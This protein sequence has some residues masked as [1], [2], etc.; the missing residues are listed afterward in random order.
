[1]KRSPLIILFITIFVDLLGFGLVIPLIPIYIQHYGG[2]PWIGGVLL[3]CYS[4]MQFIFSPI[5]GRASDRIGR[6]PL[7]L[8]SLFGS[9]ISFVA[10]GAAGTLAVLFIARVSAGILSAASL[11]AAYAYIADVT[12]PEKR[13]SGMA[14]I[15]AAFGLGFALGPAISGPLS[16]HPVFGIPPLAMPAYFAA[17]LCT[18]NFIWAFFNLPETHT[19]RSAHSE[20]KGVM[21]ILNGIGRALKDPSVKYQLTVFAFATFAFTAVESTFSWLTILRFKDEIDKGALAAWH[22]YSHLSFAAVPLEVRRLIPKGVP[23]PSYADR[24]LSSIDPPIARLLMEKAAASITTKIFMIVGITILF[25]QV[26]VMRG[27]AAKFGEKRLIIT[28]ALILTVTLFGIAMAQS[29]LWIEI[30]SAFIAVGNGI[31]NPCLSSLISQAA[32]KLNRGTVLGAQQ[33]IG[34]LARIIAP[35]INNY[36]VGLNSAIPFIASGCL[37]GMALGLS[38]ALRNP[39]L[40]HSGTNG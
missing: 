24:S 5:W 11:P 37:M 17:L 26:A 19:D 27:I 33:G 10:F 40:Q 38:T 25:V 13:A 31:M 21:D 8:L 34:S 12:S 28:G 20:A 22:G 16:Q 15:G 14:L 1:M 4:M 35:P 3:A 7:I 29:L 18:I 39:P 32:G 23:W 36:L 6:R 2:K 9:A 30:L